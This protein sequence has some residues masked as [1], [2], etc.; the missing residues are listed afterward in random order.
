MVLGMLI[1]MPGICFSKEKSDSILLNKIWSYRR[2]FAHKIGG[3]KPNVYIRYTLN[4]ERRNPTLYLIPTFFYY[5]Q[6]KREFLSETYGKLRLL[7]ENDYRIDRQ[8]ICNT[9]PHGNQVTSAFT[10]Y[11]VPDIYGMTLY[12]DRILSPFYRKNR[13]TSRTESAFRIN[14]PISS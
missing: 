12:D 7:G 13:I 8:I 11:I 3:E 1:F 4:T 9:E 6:G 14:A 2:N 5:A 10:D